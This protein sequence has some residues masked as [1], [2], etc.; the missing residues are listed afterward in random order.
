M[1]GGAGATDPND[2][3]Q[4]HSPKAGGTAKH[5]S[6]SAAASEKEPSLEEL[7]QTKKLTLPLLDTIMEKFSD[8]SA[9]HLKK[10]F[11]ATFSSMILDN[12]E[13]V[14]KEERAHWNEIENAIAGLKL[15]SKFHGPPWAVIGAGYK[16]NSLATYHMKR[17]LKVAEDG[18]KAGKDATAK[19]ELAQRCLR[20]AEEL[21]PN[22]SDV[23]RDYEKKEI[24][25]LRHKLKE[26]IAGEPA[27]PA[28]EKDLTNHGVQS[29]DVE[30]AKKLLLKS[31][32]KGKFENLT[33]FE[34]QIA[35]YITAHCLTIER[36]KDFVRTSVDDS[37]QGVNEEAIAKIVAYSQEVKKAVH[38]KTATWPQVENACASLYLIIECAS[39]F[40]DQTQAKDLG[41]GI[42][43]F[44]DSLDDIITAGIESTNQNIKKRASRA[45]DLCEIFVHRDP[46][47]SYI[48]EKR[49]A[50][51]GQMLPANKGERIGTGATKK[52]NSGSGEKL[53]KKDSKVRPESTKQSNA[54]AKNWRSGLASHLLSKKSLALLTGLAAIGA[55][56]WWHHYTDAQKK[57][58]ASVTKK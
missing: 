14:A 34:E 13:A 5:E 43:L 10:E 48:V 8:G 18:I 22:V 38:A 40:E 7:V 37:D 30:E 28:A 44:Y 41:N 32:V 27:K 49:R 24:D 4:K 12:A 20:M 55:A 2:A 15:I 23:I 58:S 17:L 35:P 33:R 46:H 9:F 25:S 45:L 51:A 47:H 36:A 11:S 1:D 31:D 57:K 56:Y 50:L 53:D 42:L 6:S 52:E 29:K 39:K 54:K 26:V 19:I 21:V 16:R 3:G